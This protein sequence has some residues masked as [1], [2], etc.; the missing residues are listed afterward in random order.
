V[1]QV[2]S[3]RSER[4]FRERAE[5]L[6][7]GSAVAAAE[8]VTRAVARGDL[9]RAVQVIAE[10]RQL[11][12]FVF[13][14]EG[15]L[16]TGP[17]SHRTELTALPERG[18]AVDRAL[19]GQR[20]IRTFDD[21]ASTLFALP[22][23]SKRAKALLAY[24]ERPEVSTGI[25]I[26]RDEIVEAALWAL[27]VGAAAGLLVALL[28]ASR[29]R[30]IAAAADA[31]EA[32]DFEK[33]LRPRFRDEFG[34]LAFTIDRMRQRLR[35]SFAEL[36]SE[37]D[38]LHRLLTR[39]HEGVLTVDASLR[40]D[41]ANPAASRLLGHRL[42][43][44]ELL[45][46]PWPE[47]SLQ[48]LARGLFRSDAAVAQARVL[49]EEDRTLAV[50]GI[51]AGQG[52]HTAVLVLTDLTEA[53]RRERAEREFVA[54]A[55]HELR[56]P[57]AA[58]ASAVEVLQ[59]GAKKIPEERDRFLEGIERQSA[60]LGR[61]TRT[62]LALARAQTREETPRLTAIELRPLLEE[63]AANI[64]PRD[65]VEV[66]VNCPPRL[67]VLADRDL[68]EQVIANVMANAA[69]YTVAGK[70]E[71]VARRLASSSVAVEVRDT[72]P[73]IGLRE[74]ER[75]FE[76][77]YRGSD[78]HPDGFGLGLAIVREAVRAMGGTVELDS[79][80]GRGTTVRVTLPLA[81]EEAA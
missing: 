51:P 27:L 78:R 31:I 5:E 68:A 76:R 65:E 73:G 28:I 80:P 46:E 16:L 70:I 42:E 35:E 3:Q 54:N 72:G 57:I 10:R 63:A 22:L 8:G 43:E 38:R 67:A 30:R 56:T 49:Q 26:V 44:G 59:A 77:F 81:A 69:K 55:A 14:G 19:S 4:A 39:L 36:E 2:F 53:E 62:L 1:A 48:G 58:I 34:A 79:L 41:F 21:G 23:P 50:V 74:Q 60:R 37:R 11:A 75:V 71:L 6:V 32:G 7:V 9:E 13:D 20:Y 33:P 61:L 18:V 17:R 66:A 12:L 24:G 15:A 29:L 40:I 25:G 45:P 64:E 52:S 47:V